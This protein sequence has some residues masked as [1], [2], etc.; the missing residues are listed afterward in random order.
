MRLFS[1]NNRLLLIVI[2]G[3]FCC[4]GGMDLPKLLAAES[5]PA[6]APA[7]GQKTIITSGQLTFETKRSPNVATFEINVVVVDPQFEIRCDKLVATFD[8]TSHQ[9]THAEAIGHVIITQTGRVARAQKATYTPEDGKIILEGEPRI[10][11]QEGNVVG[12]VIT[13]FRNSD[14]IIVSGGTRME[15]QPE[16]K[17]PEASPQSPTNPQPR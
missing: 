9:I 17:K 3:G 15:V 14:K 4:Y 1:T 7:G 16:E 11:S 6:A 12:K 13:Y 5:Q 10:E 8:S 2:I